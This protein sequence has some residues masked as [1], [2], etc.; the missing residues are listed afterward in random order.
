MD[1]SQ[2]SDSERRLHGAWHSLSWPLPKQKAMAPHHWR[3]I[4]THHTISEQRQTGERLLVF[5]L[6]LLA[7]AQAH[8]LAMNERLFERVVCAVDGLRMHIRS[9]YAHVA[10]T[11]DLSP[12]AYVDYVEALFFTL[13]ADREQRRYVVHLLRAC[14][15][16]H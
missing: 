15:S 7:P 12:E 6:L 16:G 4:T 1:A 9:V 11:P 13:L 3:T 10:G 5:H 8:N 2:L 14:C